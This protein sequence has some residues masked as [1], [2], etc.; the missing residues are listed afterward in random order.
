[1][2]HLLYEGILQSVFGSLHAVQEWQDWEEWNDSQEPQAVRELR[3][4]VETLEKILGLDSRRLRARKRRLFWLKP[5]QLALMSRFFPICRGN[6]RVDD[7][8]V[9]SGII[10]VLMTGLPLVR[11]AGGV[12]LAED[13]IQP[14]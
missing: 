12:W 5:E 1:M 13:L 6:P 3:E 14:L 2:K 11:C 4:L 7:L 9:L 8:Q 10:F